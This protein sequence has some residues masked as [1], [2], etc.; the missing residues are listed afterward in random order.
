MTGAVV[1]P[2]TG[3]VSNVVLRA[4][5]DGRALV[6]KQALPRLSVEAVWEAKQERT[7]TEAAALR[8]AAQLTPHAVPK[9]VHLDKHAYILVIEA[10][11]STIVDWREELLAGRVRPEVGERLGAVLATWHGRTAEDPSLA[12]EIDDPETFDQLRVDPFYRTV[13]RRHPSLAPH[14]S[15]LIEELTTRRECFVHGDFSPKNVLTGAADWVVDFEVAHV[16]TPAFDVAFLLSHLLLKSLH[17]TECREA[18]R[19]TASAFWTAYAAPSGLEEVTRH[20]GALLLARVD[21][22]SPAPYLTHREKRA[23]WDMGHS[24]LRKPVGDIDELWNGVAV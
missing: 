1:A 16:G 3:G 8:L 11:E 5:A 13:L 23:A 15:P 24:L 10:A 17:R 7:V 19:T 14:L 12:Q 21:G 20:V 4:E 2:L 18:H 22:K 9:V 6:V